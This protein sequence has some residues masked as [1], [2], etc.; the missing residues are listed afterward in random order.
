M[1]CRIFLVAS[2]L[3]VL[4]RAAFGPKDCADLI[5][6][7]NV[8]TISDRT[9]KRYWEHPDVEMLASKIKNVKN[10]SISRYPFR[11]FAK[12]GESE[13]VLR[14]IVTSLMSPRHLK[15]FFGF[16]FYPSRTSRKYD[17]VLSKVV[18]GILQGALER[19]RVNP[20]L[21][22]LEIHAPSIMNKDLARTLERV[23]FHDN[24]KR[25]GFKETG[26]IAIGSYRSLGISVDL[27]SVAATGID[28]HPSIR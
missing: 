14:V 26:Q 17:P 13:G 3:P 25:I 5:E 19:R 12:V 2:V 15:A 11:L 21:R 20:K 4:G 8:G 10:V 7:I 27:S 24:G 9:I 18:V 22:T 28:E 1:I 23:G 16:Y 6:R